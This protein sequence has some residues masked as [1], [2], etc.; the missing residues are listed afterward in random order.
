MK[1]GDSQIEKRR[2][3]D[4]NPRYVCTY[5]AFPVPHLRP[6]GHLSG[7]TPRIHLAM[8]CIDPHLGRFPRWVG[9]RAGWESVALGA[10]IRGYQMRGAAANGGW[11]RLRGWRVSRVVR[12]SKLRAAGP[13][14][15]PP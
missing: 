11:R 1:S 8:T 2:G 4:S 9:P 14:A 3:R 13:P 12:R 15:H 7:T 6:L 5:T 10:E